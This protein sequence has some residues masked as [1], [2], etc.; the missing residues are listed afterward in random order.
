MSEEQ[1]VSGNQYIWQLRIRVDRRQSAVYRLRVLYV[2]C[3]VFIEGE[4]GNKVVQYSNL[5]RFFDE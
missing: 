4:T 2:Y 1:E 3:L 5:L